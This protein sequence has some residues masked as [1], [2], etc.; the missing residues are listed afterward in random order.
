MTS[1]HWYNVALVIGVLLVGVNFWANRIKNQESQADVDGL[2]SQL[3][4]TRERL[5]QKSD[6]LLQ[7]SAKIEA[8]QHELIAENEKIKTLQAQL[9]AKSQTIEELQRY[10]NGELRH[11]TGYLTGGDS[12]PILVFSS[13]QET[14]HIWTSQM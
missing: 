14:P 1:T 13:S 11:Q 6:E 2:N 4:G 12:F 9:L 10:A 8:L 5:N 7:K 3:S